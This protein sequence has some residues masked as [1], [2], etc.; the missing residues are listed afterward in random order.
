MQV[1]RKI[2]EW[3]G[4]ILFFVL[5]YLYLWRVVDLRLIYHGGGVVTN[6]PVFYTGWG[7][8]RECLCH[9]GGVVV[10]ASAFLAQFF[11]IGWAGALVATVQAFL[12]WLCTRVIVSVVSGWRVRWVCFVPSIL[13][14]VSYAM[15]S[16][17]FT[18][19]MTVLAA[20]GFVCL[21]LWIVSKGRVPSLLVFLALSIIVYATTG[22]GYLLFTAICAIYEL[23]VRRRQI[24]CVMYLLLAP[25]VLQVVGM[26]VF[27]EGIVDTLLC[28]RPFSRVGGQ[29]MVEGMMTMSYT[30]YL[31]VPVAVSGLWLIRRFSAGPSG[32]LFV[33]S[34][35]PV[36]KVIGLALPFVIGVAACGLLHN[37]DLKTSLEVDYYACQKMWP[38]VLVAAKRLARDKFASHAVNRA[39][40][41]TGRLAEDM[42]AYPQRSEAMLVPTTAK[43]PAYWAGFDSF[44][45]LGQ[46]N[47]A[48]Y[49]LGLSM[50]ANGERP[51]I[52]KRLA[53]VDMAKGNIGRG[54]GEG[55]FGENRDGPEPVNGYGGSAPAKLYGG[56]GQ[57]F[58]RSKN[59]Y[60]HAAGPSRQ[61]QTEPDDFR[62]HDGGIFI[63]VAVRQVH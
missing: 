7:F 28:F 23:L 27:D 54:V 16:Y 24:V 13:L 5:Y 15:Y 20:L 46:V 21:Y 30:F 50:E 4:H 12:M 3:A 25:I 17:Q 38:E 42:F 18:A 32:G 22:A 59:R 33:W 51:I 56:Q 36:S 55:V 61:K 63:D 49:L 60:E 6:F 41:H 52:L 26:L 9:P 19:G 34:E 37:S 57:V 35:K 39:L 14:L 29:G 8:F 40:Y 2:S 31:F 11:Y 58:S 1:L 45:D 48:G 62:V 43:L 53:L 47:L 10:Y 44:I